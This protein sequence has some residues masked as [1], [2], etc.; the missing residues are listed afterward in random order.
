LLIFAPTALFLFLRS[1]L[2]FSSSSGSW[3]CFISYLYLNFDMGNS[4]GSRA[5]PG[6]SR[7][8]SMRWKFKVGNLGP[9]ANANIAYFSLIHNIFSAQNCQYSLLQFPNL[10]VISTSKILFLEY[11]RVPHN[12][13]KLLTI[14]TC[15]HTYAEIL[16]ICI[17]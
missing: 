2:L 8:Q 17:T 14:V 13:F 6:V 3:F 10:R 5:E 1:R 12:T 11:S 4:C 16:Y 7:L 15:T 9:A